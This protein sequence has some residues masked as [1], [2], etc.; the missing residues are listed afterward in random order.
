MA[1]DL[2]TFTERR[3]YAFHLT[4]RRNLVS[5]IHGAR[6]DSA[7]TLIAK[8]GRAELP[9]TRRRRH[10]TVRIDGREISLRDQAPLHAKN[11]ALAEGYT[12]DDFVESLNQRVFF[13]PGTEAGPIEHGRRHFARYEAERPVLVRAKTSELIRANMRA[14]P[15]FCRYNSGSPRWSGGLA[16]PRGPDTF[17][18]AQ[19]FPGPASDA[20]ELTFPSAVLLPSTW[21]IGSHPNGPWTEPIQKRTLTFAESRFF[22]DQLRAARAE[23]VQDAEGFHGIVTALESLGSLLHPGGTGLGHY[24][25]DLVQIARRALT[26]PS[27][28]DDRGLHTPIEALYRAVRNGR[29]DAVHQGAYARHLVRHCT[30]LALLIEEGLME[31]RD[32]IG[33]F[34]V[35]DPV[36]AE[37]WQPVSMARQKMLAASFSYLPVRVDEK[38]MLLSDHAIARYLTKADQPK[39]AVRARIGVA[40]EEGRLELRSAP[41]VDP[42]EPVAQALERC[43][44]ALLIVHEGRL[45]GIATPFDFL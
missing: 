26:A 24:E 8:D 12:F 10:V 1:F 9:R 39:D 35:S 29:N 16:S 3:P 25:A 40:Y 36:C 37:A 27:G 11:M 30:E 2:E 21:E 15:E 34:M 5:I 4:S 41:V 19:D 28:G 18:A 45:L 22:R 38:W 43:D 6:I 14:T 31:G 42:A 33:D 44:G 17:L 13:W 7:A 20:V 23:A 32:T